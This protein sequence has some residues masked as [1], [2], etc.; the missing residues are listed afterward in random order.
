MGRGMS[1]R[2]VDEEQAELEGR[3]RSMNSAEPSDENP[4]AWLAEQQQLSYQ[5]Q[6][7]HHQQLMMMMR[8][9]QVI[10]QQN[11][12]VRQLVQE[13]REQSLEDRSAQAFQ[14]FWERK[15]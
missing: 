12:E 2:N 6:R 11:L 15:P 13:Q 4:W 1:R 14:E 9:H 10:A 5:Q 8:Q 3:M 7:I